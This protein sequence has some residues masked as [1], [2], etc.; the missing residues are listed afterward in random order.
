MPDLILLDIVMP[1]MNGFELM[2]IL[3]SEAHT[4]DVPI[5][6]ITA[7]DDGHV[8][9]ESLNAGAVD[10]ITKPFNHGVV[11]RRVDNFMELL[12]Y[13]RR[14]EYMVADK[15]AELTATKDHMIES[16]AAVIEYR[17]LESGVH[18][19]RTTS[20]AALIVDHCMKHPRF[21][22][23][24]RDMDHATMIKAAPLHDVGKITVPDAVL[25]K[26]GLLN[27]D[28]RA[29][30]EEHTTKGGEIIS[31]MMRIHEDSYFR[32]CYDIAMYHHEN[33]DGS[34]Y[35]AGLAGEDIPISA[36]IVKIVDVYDAL[37]SKRVYKPAMT[38]KEAMAI[39]V[40]DSGTHF[41]PNLVELLLQI[42]DE[43]AQ[44]ADNLRDPE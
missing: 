25:L 16:M 43:F 1:Q 4:K 23:S 19:K 44:Y 34:G 27:S 41:D 21:R 7:E 2:S 42:E 28:E 40:K 13:R 30:I 8:E 20:L 15:V 38:H 14:L 11:R 35:P 22:I 37:I 12:V 36:R 17:N 9:L 29:I 10:Y 33:W 26:P 32:H 6:F 18:V 39:I 5:I 3:K 31:S 24:L